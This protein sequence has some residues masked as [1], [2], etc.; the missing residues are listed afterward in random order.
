MVRKMLPL[1]R[2]HSEFTLMTSEQQRALFKLRALHGAAVFISKLHS[3][4][5]ALDQL[6]FCLGSQDQEYF[7]ANV[8]QVKAHCYW[9]GER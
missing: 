6:N 7:R 2:E 4:G 9:I 5:K 8:Q 1:Y 3:Y